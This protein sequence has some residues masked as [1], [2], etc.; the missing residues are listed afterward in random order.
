MSLEEALSNSVSK[1]GGSLSVLSGDLEQP[2]LSLQV[3]THNCKLITGH[4]IYKQN[5]LLLPSSSSIGEI[6]SKCWF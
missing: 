1:S 2:K 3:K 4:R 5:L 6:V